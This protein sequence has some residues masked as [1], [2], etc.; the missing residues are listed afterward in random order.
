[1]VCNKTCQRSVG[2]PSLVY[3]WNRPDLVDNRKGKQVGEAGLVDKNS[4]GSLCNIGVPEI[5]SDF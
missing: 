5:N 3:S 1:M 2:K 4:W